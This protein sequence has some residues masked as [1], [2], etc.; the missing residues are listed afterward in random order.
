MITFCVG[1]MHLTSSGSFKL[2]QLGRC[3]CHCSCLFWHRTKVQQTQTDR[4]LIRAP[5]PDYIITG[6]LS[7]VGPISSYL[8]SPLG[9]CGYRGGLNHWMEFIWTF[10][11]EKIIK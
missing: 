9:C 8:I 11:I 2:L 1:K 7:S 4:L 6:I 10:I 5:L 3:L